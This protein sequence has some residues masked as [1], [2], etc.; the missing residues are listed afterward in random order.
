MKYM[1]ICLIQKFPIILY[2]LGGG[3]MTHIATKDP[4]KQ[5]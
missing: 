3:K 5:D 2:V 4:E 1:K